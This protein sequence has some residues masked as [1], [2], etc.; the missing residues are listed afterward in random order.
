MTGSTISPGF[1]AR[2]FAARRLRAIVWLA[3]LVSSVATG[4]E[5]VLR[6]VAKTETVYA[7]AMDAMAAK[8]AI[9]SGLTSR[10]GGRDRRG[11]EARVSRQARE[12]G[13]DAGE[14]SQSRPGRR[15]YTGHS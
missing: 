6:L 3:C 11:W 2:A 14:A 5:P 8:E 4:K 9:D 12:I 10:Y 7:D 15:R 1:H 13:R